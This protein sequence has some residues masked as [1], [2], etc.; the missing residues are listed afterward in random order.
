MKLFLLI[1]LILL[2]LPQQEPKHIQCKVETQPIKLIDCNY[3]DEEDIVEGGFE[4]AVAEKWKLSLSQA[5]H[6]EGTAHFEETAKEICLRQVRPLDG[7]VRHPVQE[8]LNLC[9]RKNKEW[10]LPKKQ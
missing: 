9:Q 8:D 6:G 5:V 3:E 10:K 2:T 4:L 1:A 7:F